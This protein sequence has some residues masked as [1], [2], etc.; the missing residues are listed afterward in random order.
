MST[1]F[2]WPG[3]KHRREGGAVESVLRMLGAAVIIVAIAAGFM[4]LVIRLSGSDAGE[5]FMVLDAER[6]AGYKIAAP[7]VPEGFRRDGAI[8]VEEALAPTYPKQVVQR[9]SLERNPGV[10]FSVTQAG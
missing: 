5:E 3:P 2:T 10:Y 1:G 4:F 8:R 7:D 6:K 9:W